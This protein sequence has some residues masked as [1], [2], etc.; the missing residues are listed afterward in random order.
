MPT[1]AAACLRVYQEQEIIEPDPNL[2]YVENFLMMAF[3]EDS[4]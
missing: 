1:I 4:Q 3:G 2:G